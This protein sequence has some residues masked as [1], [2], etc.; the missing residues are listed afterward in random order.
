M[1]VGGGDGRQQVVKKPV[2]LGKEA[3]SESGTWPKCC[4]TFYRIAG[5]HR[6]PRSKSFCFTDAVLVMLLPILSLCYSS[7]TVQLPDTSPMS[8][9]NASCQ[10]V[11]RSIPVEH[12]EDRA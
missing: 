1:I 12:G 10:D 2:S 5:E 6:D 9:L 11:L 8:D 7:E 4:I 3:V